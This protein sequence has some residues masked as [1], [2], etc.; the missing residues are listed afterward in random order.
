MTTK[1]TLTKYYSF[2]STSIIHNVIDSELSILNTYDKLFI[3]ELY[4]SLLDYLTFKFGF[5]KSINLFYS[6]LSQNNFADA[7]ALLY[8]LFP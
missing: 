4:F 8:L 2:H 5:E 6:Q 3:T 7:K 1:K